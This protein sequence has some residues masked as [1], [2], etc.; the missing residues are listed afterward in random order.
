M[1]HHLQ[2]WWDEHLELVIG[3]GVLL[4]VI[5]LSFIA[6]WSG[7][8]RCNGGAYTVYPSKHWEVRLV[9]YDGKTWIPESHLID[10]TTYICVV[11]SGAQ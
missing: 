3:V 5:G 10:T 2:L 9:T 7:T 4:L 11:D 8:P 1:M 6:F